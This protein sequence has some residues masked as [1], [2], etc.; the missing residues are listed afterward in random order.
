MERTVPFLT[1][2]T[3][4][5]SSSARPPTS[6]KRTR[7]TSV[8]SARR[9]WRRNVTLQMTTAMATRT[10]MPTAISA[11]REAM[12]PPR[13]REVDARALDE[14]AH[15][16]IRGSA[17]LLRRAVEPDAPLVQQGDPVRDDVRALHVVRH[18]D[19]ADA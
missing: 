10:V 13:L 12:L 5:G 19:R 1:P 16:R 8:R 6:V 14:L 11:L 17:Q 7:H 18:H 15:D 3:D 2:L 9:S 4:T